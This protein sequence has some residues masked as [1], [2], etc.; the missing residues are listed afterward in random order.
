MTLKIR[1]VVKHMDWPLLRAQK[2]YCA[3]EAARHNDARQMFDGLAHL[4][5]AMQDAA[6]RDHIASAEEVFGELSNEG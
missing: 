3:S 5:D 1:H 2:A 4:I 6:V